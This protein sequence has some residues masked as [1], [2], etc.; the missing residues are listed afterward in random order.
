MSVVSSSTSAGVDE[1]DVETWEA[2][3]VWLAP[4]MALA[5]AGLVTLCLLRG[6]VSSLVTVW[7]NSSTY[8]YGL[9]VVP[10][11]ALLVWRRRS[12]LKSLP[13]MTS[14]V[15]LFAFLFSAVVWMGGNIADVQEVQHL[16]LIGLIVAMVWTFLGTPVLRVLRFPLLFLFLSVPVGD[17]LVPTLQQI[18]A[19]VTVNALRWSGIPVVLD[20]LILSTPSGNWTIAEACSGIRYLF[21]SILVGVL[22]AG[23]AYRSWKRRLVF[24]LASICVP[25][26]ANAIRAYGIV[27]LGYITDNRFA[28][29]VDHVLYGWIFFSLT[30][31]MLVLVGTKWS[32]AAGETSATNT[33]PEVLSQGVG[34]YVPSVVALVAVMVIATSVTRVAG[35]LWS[36][37]LASSPAARVILPEGW[38]ATPD[39]DYDWAPHPRAIQ[40]ATAE[41]WRYGQRRVSLY[42][43]VYSGGQRGVELVSSVN[44][45]DAASTWKRVSS[46]RRKVNIAGHPVEVIENLIVRNDERELV[47]L[48][49]AVGDKLTASPYEIRAVQAKN[50]L[51]RHPQGVALFAASTPFLSD[52]SEASELLRQVLE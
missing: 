30:T 49:Y 23:M 33:K 35:Y 21:A 1:S 14:I 17:S 13:P 32:E 47:W 25:V 3:A 29:G 22:F 26:V 27:V 46:S 6:T 51:L 34:S 44:A 39:R 15:G 42:Q 12:D 7:Y 11:T 4:L 20:D 31:A 37:P 24:V 36:L 10:L 9:V 28:A 5:A 45:V 40:S 38:A 52:P 18:T 16:A 43:G 19:S 48:W 8:S 50:R 2:A 41:T